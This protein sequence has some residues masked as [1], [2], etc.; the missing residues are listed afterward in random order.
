V[1]NVLFLILAGGL[2]TQWI[3]ARSAWGAEQVAIFALAIACLLHYAWVRK[4]P[5]TGLSRL[6]LTGAVAIGCLQLITNTTVDRWATSEQILTWLTWLAAHGI[7]L[8]LCSDD[9]VRLR[10]FRLA[11]GLGIALAVL[12]ILHRTTSAGKV[13]WWFETGRSFVMGVFPYENQYAAFVLVVL[14]VVLIEGLTGPRNRLA[15]ML[16]AAIMVGSVI[17]S[18]AVAGAMLVLLEPVAVVAWI[19]RRSRGAIARRAVGTLVAVLAVA[20][21]IGFIGGWK[22]MVNDLERRNPLALRQNLS[23]STIAMA[24]D[25]WSTG[26]GLGTWTEVYP[27]YA[28]FD[29]GVFDNA[30]HNDWAQWAAE[31]GVGML[32]MLVLFLFLLV[33][34]AGRT[35]LAIGLV[36]ALLHDLIEFHF[37]ERLAF[38]CFFFAFAGAVLAAASSPV[39]NRPVARAVLPPAV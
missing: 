4:E 3:P 31:G 21:A 17:S 11:G 35:P 10:F 2:A 23:A 36:L 37:Q 18:A 20:V 27:A 7:A 12:A 29:D 33:R 19:T 24:R 28:R 15:W 22:D 14:P 38:G 25:R 34:A 39:E 16:G 26:W 32:A 9:A 5:T 1:S 13:F 6:P 8:H 30:A